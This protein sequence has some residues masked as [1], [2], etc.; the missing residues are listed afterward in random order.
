[1]RAYEMM[2]IFEAELEDA[3]VQA[4]LKQVD[5]LVVAAGGTVHK[6][7]MW[8]KRRFA[9]EIDHKVEGIYVVLELTTDGGDLN[10]M[11][12]YLRLA[13]EVVRHKLLRLP[14]REAARRGLYGEEAAAAAGVVP[15]AAPEADPDATPE[16]A[17][18]EAAPEAAADEAVPADAG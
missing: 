1:M 6:T 13:D 11:D 17:P 14:D 2:V 8:G 7:D 10:P 5:D 12:R 4:Q 15:A 16:V 9:Y 3:D 18:D